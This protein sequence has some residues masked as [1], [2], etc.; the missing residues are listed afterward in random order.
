MFFHQIDWLGVYFG[1]IPAAVKPIQTFLMHGK[2]LVQDRMR[3][4]SSMRDL[5]HYLV[6][7]RACGYGSL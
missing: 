5:F 6:R 2:K 1:Q 4:G 3:R 7:R